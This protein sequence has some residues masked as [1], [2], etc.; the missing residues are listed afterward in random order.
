MRT[1]EVVLILEDQPQGSVSFSAQV[2][3]PGQL[4]DNQRFQYRALKLNTK[5]WPTPLQN[6][7]GY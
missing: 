7:A 3:S 1:R 5:A 2:L 6:S 4:R